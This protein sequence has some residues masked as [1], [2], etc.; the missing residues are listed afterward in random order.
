MKGKNCQ[1]LSI[2]LTLRTLGTGLKVEWWIPSTAEENG[3]KKATA[4][5]SKY[6]LNKKWYQI[7][8]F[9]N[10][11]KEELTKVDHEATNVKIE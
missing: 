5:K 1:V 10:I 2:C 11:N 6:L 8:M 4:N 3:G 9:E 7:Q